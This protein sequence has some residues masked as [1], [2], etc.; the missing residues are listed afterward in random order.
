VAYISQTNPEMH[1]VD[2][3]YQRFHV[4]ITDLKIDPI[5]NDETKTNELPAAPVLPKTGPK[6]KSLPKGKAK[7]AAPPP[8]LF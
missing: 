6:W 2:N 5:T 7:P 4:K 8:T 1:L 3:G